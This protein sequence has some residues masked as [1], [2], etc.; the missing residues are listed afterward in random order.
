MPGAFAQTRTGPEAPAPSSIQPD[1]VALDKVASRAVGG[2]FSSSS[3]P[4]FESAWHPLQVV[5]KLTARGLPDQAGL[6]I[7]LYRYRYRRQLPI[8]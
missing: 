3:R 7:E 5:P 2:E 8:G 4:C 6:K 1:Q